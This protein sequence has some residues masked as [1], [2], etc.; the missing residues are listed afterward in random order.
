MYYHH[1][2]LLSVILEFYARG[3]LTSDALFTDDEYSN[4]DLFLNQNNPDIFLPDNDD[5]DINTSL[6]RTDLFPSDALAD[7][8]DPTTFSLA[9]NNNNNP[10]ANCDS[11]SSFPLIKARS[12]VSSDAC[13]KNPA[14]PDPSSPIFKKEDTV[15]ETQEE[16]E[17]WWCS[18]NREQDR[19][20]LPVCAFTYENQ[21]VEIMLDGFACSFFILSIF[22]YFS[23]LFFLSSSSCSLQI[24]YSKKSFPH[25]LSPPLESSLKEKISSTVEE[26]EKLAYT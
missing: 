12:S 1:V 26:K 22:F 9:N 14:N 20:K 10:A 19:G 3:A 24:T 6:L 17:R 15:Q 18:G 23:F 7:F 21:D 16:V 8:D 11:S 25:P 2:F 13:Q 5:D 4:N